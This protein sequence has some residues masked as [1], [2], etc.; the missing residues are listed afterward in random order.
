[1]ARFTKARLTKA[2][3]TK[4]QREWRPGMPRKRRSV[5][6]LFASSVLSLEAF[7]VFFATLA[8]YG[9]T[10]LP[11]AALLTAGLTL[12]ALLLGTCGVLSRPWG[13]VVGWVLQLF[14]I[15]TG[16]VIPLMYV[17]GGLFA[18]TWWYGLRT[19]ARI[20]RENARRDLE[21]QEWERNHPEAG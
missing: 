12:S 2:Q 5:R 7:V 8:A 3:L 11:R 20:D 14:V 17:I 1:M 16:L 6:V 21:Q 18:L 4:A 9:L 10:D 13:A 15:A 19:G